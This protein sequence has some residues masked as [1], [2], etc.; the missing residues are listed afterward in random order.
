MLISITD[1]KKTIKLYKVLAP[2]KTKKV[3]DVRTSC[4]GKYHPR[5]FP[6]SISP[7]TTDDVVPTRNNPGSS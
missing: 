3:P 4:A 7:P 5:G 2:N 1:K 6:F